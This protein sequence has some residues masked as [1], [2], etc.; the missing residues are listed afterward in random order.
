M[1]K[2]KVLLSSKEVNIILHRLTSQLIERFNPSQIT[3]ADT[4]NIKFTQQILVDSN[5]SLFKF[6]FHNLIPCLLKTL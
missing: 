5:I 3:V 6:L 1:I 4:E 2:Q